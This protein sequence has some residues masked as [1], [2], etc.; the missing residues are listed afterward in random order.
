MLRNLAEY[1]ITTFG[2]LRVFNSIIFASVL[3]LLGAFIASL[4]LAPKIIAF[5]ARRKAIENMHKASVLIERQHAEKVGTPTMGGAI[6]IVALIMMALL[7]CDLNSWLV[8]AGIIIFSGNGLI[9]FIDDYVKL[10]GHKPGLNKKQKTLGLIIVAMIGVWIFSQTAQVDTTKILLPFT[11]WENVQPDLGWFYYAYFVFVIYACSNAV[12]LTD[13]LDGLASGC[14]ITAAFTF[15]AFAYVAGNS[16]LCN[17]FLIPHV[18]GCGELTVLIFALIGAVMGFLWFNA[19]P[20]KIFMGDTGSLA[21]GGLIGY[22]ALASKQEIALIIA[23]GIFVA[24]AVSVIIQIISFRF[25]HKR[26][27]LCAPLHHHLELSGWKENHIVVRLWMIGA[28]LSAIALGT[29]KF[30]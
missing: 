15:A 13:G 28:I 25:W 22:L 27:F 3:S 19:N 11:K 24:E 18:A 10:R 6:I 5:L 17:Y 16:G 14:S 7:F 21:I 26:V 23:G 1:F 12:N 30:H 9:G 8:W 29:L 20:A 4:W 2:P